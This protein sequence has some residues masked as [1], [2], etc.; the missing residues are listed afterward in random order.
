LNIEAA[1]IKGDF[2]T[3]NQLHINGNIDHDTLEIKNMTFDYGE[4]KIAS[5]FIIHLGQH[6]GLHIKGGK[7]D[8]QFNQ[9]N[10]DELLNV[11]SKYN[12]NTGANNLPQNIDLELDLS[13][14]NGIILDRAFSNLDIDVSFSKG[15]IEI[16]NLETE[17]LGGNISL[18]SDIKYNSDG[19]W[20]I[21]ADGNAIFSNLSARELL[22]DFH[23]KEKSSVKPKKIPKIPEI[24]DINIGIVVDS[25]LYGTETFSDIQTE[26]KVS[27]D[28]IDIEDFSIELNEGLGQIDLKV[29]DY[30]K[31]EPRI[32][33]NIDLRIDSANVQTIYETMSGFSTNE[34]HKEEQVAHTIPYNIDINIKLNARYLQYQSHIIENLQLAGS[35][36]DGVLSIADINFNTSGGFIEFSG[37]FFQNMNKTIDGHF[38]SSGTK[39]SI[40]PLLNSF[41][42]T[43]LSDGKHGNIQGNISYE[44]EGLFQ[45]DS[46]LYLVNDQ[47]LLYADIIIDNRHIMNNPQLDNTL[48]FIGHKAKDS[49]T[50]KNSEFQIFINGSDIIIQDILVNNNISDMNIF[51]KYY[52]YDSAI[53]LNFRVSLMDLFFRTKKKRYVDTEQGE[54]RLLK[55]LSIFIE[56]DNSS[57]KNKIKIHP[58]R[59]HRMKRKDLAN[60]IAEIVTKYRTRLNNLYLKA[61]P[62]FQDSEMPLKALNK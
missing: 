36:S 11:Q 13:V 16:K 27:R 10:I 50:V 15:D 30:L 61:E 32:T 56:L 40:E 1:E 62:E 59:K 35:I 33:G 49:I 39:L 3:I 18:N 45:L 52:L 4:G 14:K 25:L 21:Q 20:F 47:N 55:D 7:I 2:G 22:N 34:K 31:Q 5:N 42:N 58:K 19:I 6:D 44:A 23:K 43:E 12:D 46:S 41:S 29:I 26:V 57:P 51:G 53:N 48:S 60:E 17:L 28:E 37:L 24:V 9:L 38:Y 54:I 8:A